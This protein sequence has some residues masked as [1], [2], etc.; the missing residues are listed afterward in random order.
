MPPDMRGVDLARLDAIFEKAMSARNTRYV[1]LGQFMFEI[2]KAI[3]RPENA[4]YA[5]HP[6]RIPM[7]PGVTTAEEARRITSQVPVITPIGDEEGFTKVESERL[8]AANDQ[9]ATA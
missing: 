2:R 1:E 5:D 7:I 8:Q 4:S 9:T 3:M 6:A